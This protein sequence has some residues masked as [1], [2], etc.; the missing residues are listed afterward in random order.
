MTS[1]IY[2]IRH[3]ASGRRYIG[4]AVDF[5]RRWQRHQQEFRRGDHFNAHLLAAW[6]AHGPEAFSFEPLIICAVADLELYEQLLLDGLAPEF[7][8]SRT[9]RS[10]RGVSH[11]RRSN[12]LPRRTAGA[13]DRRKRVSVFHW[14][15]RARRTPR[16]RAS[17]CGW[18]RS[19]GVT[20]PMR[21]PIWAQPRPRGCGRPLNTTAA[22]A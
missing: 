9:A 12:G 18:R 5:R 14:P 3:I 16:P 20:P 22:G 8:I 2:Q 6:R 19:A 17:K 1:G 13:P 4:Q 11:A 21:L 15:A 7:N 10:R